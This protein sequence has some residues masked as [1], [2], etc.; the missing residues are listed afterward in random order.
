MEKEAIQFVLTQ[1]SDYLNI[2]YDGNWQSLW[3]VISSKYGIREIIDC[4]EELCQLLINESKFGRKFFPSLP[5]GVSEQELH[6]FYSSVEWKK[7]RKETLEY[8]ERK[9]HRC[10]STDDVAVDHIQSLRRFWHLRLDKNNLQLLCK[11]CNQHKGSIF[12]V[13][14]R[15]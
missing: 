11:K 5:E 9:C 8:Y 13:D 14:Y 1:F 10:D 2:P 6:E 7:L 4:D 12:I 3:Q 15:T